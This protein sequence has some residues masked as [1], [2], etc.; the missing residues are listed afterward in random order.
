[1]TGAAAGAMRDHGW[2]ILISPAEKS[3]ADAAEEDSI[4]IDARLS[5]MATLL[6]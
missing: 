2:P 3:C 6:E 5:A 4:V 1:M